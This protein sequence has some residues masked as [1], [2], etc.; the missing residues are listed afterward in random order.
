MS[1]TPA[2]PSH[3]GIHPDTDPVHAWRVSRLISLGLNWVAAEAIADRIDWHAVA[4]LV[5]RGCPVTLAVAIVG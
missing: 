1:S 5:R 2:D 3:E 4:R